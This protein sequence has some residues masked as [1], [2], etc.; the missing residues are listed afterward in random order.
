[1]RT[2]RPLFFFLT[3]LLLLLLFLFHTPLAIEGVQRG[4]SLFAQSVLPAL[5]PFLVLSELILSSGIGHV[6]GRVL[7]RPLGALFGVSE[8]GGGALL[9]GALCGQPVASSSAVSLYERGE[10]SKDEARRISLFAN[11]P[12]SGFLIAAVGGTLFGNAS[13]GMALFC[14]TMLSSALLG[15][16]LR[17]CF[18]K[19]DKM[20][21]KYRNGID[22][23]PF[24]TLF[25]EAV[26][27]GFFCI[28]QIGAFLVFFSSLSNVLSG[29]FART[30][31][32][33][34]WQH[35]LFG[36]LEITAG[37]HTAV[38]TLPAYSA[39]RLAAFLCGFGGICVCMQILS[40]TQKCEVSA[41]H[42]LIAK[43]FQGGIALL[44]GEGYLRLLHPVLTPVQSIPTGIL[45]TNAS[46]ITIACYTLFLI[47]FFTFSK[48]KATATKGINGC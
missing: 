40:I 23:R 28:L 20:V 34:K 43:L 3:P 18:G 22:N 21:K 38:T 30:P 2:L 36:A 24:F 11:N 33:R 46:L 14:I 1:M 29:F 31:Y 48:R 10:I 7:A 41:L 26:Q 8:A 13:A 25:T 16:T 19:T 4:L 32:D 42:Y 6:I 27:R 47:I 37:I 44:L 45:R 12:S 5:F 39:F 35:L 9:L 17:L 15:M